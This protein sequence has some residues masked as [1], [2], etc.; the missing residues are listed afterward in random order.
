MAV[1]GTCYVSIRKKANL[2]EDEIKSKFWIR[3]ILSDFS[4][5]KLTKTTLKKSAFY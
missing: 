4:G 1:S 3:I 5:A 2:K